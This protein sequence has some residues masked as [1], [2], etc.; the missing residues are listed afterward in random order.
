MIRHNRNAKNIALPPQGPLG[1][2]PMRFPFLALLVFMAALSGC[3]PTRDL[4]VAPE[5][6]QSIHLW[7]KP[8]GERVNVTY[9]TGGHYDPEAMSRIDHIFRDRHQNEVYPMDPRLIDLIADLRDRMIMPPDTEIE[10][11]SGYRSQETNTELA[12][13]NRHVAK[14]SYHMKGQAADIRIP[15]MISSVL[16]HVAKTLQR[17]GVALYPDSG[18]VHVDTGPIRGWAVYRGAEPGMKRSTSRD[19][20][21]HGRTSAPPDTTY[22]APLR[23][24]GNLK[25]IEDSYSDLPSVP[26]HVPMHKENHTGTP[27]KPG[28]AASKTAVPAAPVQSKKPVQDAKKQWVKTPYRK[29]AA[30]ALKPAHRAA[31]KAAPKTK[32]KS[33]TTRLPN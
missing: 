9:R 8:S 31:P 15:D 24:K 12:K 14:Q 32:S 5:G 16:E 25:A 26:S 27:K 20:H 30:P 33:G 21:F 2:E 11:L 10:V 23:I 28:K 18:H 7:H 17:G 3:A 19:E 1:F 29:P 22:R 13:T 6:S 4:T